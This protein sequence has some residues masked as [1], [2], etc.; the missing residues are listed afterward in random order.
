MRA[1]QPGARVSVCAALL[2]WLGLGLGLGLGFGLG[3]G[4]GLDPNPNQHVDA[5]EARD[6]GVA[7]GLDER[8]LVR[9]RD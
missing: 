6:D 2:T 7:E 5:R 9:A 8:H 3:L 1:N 4:L